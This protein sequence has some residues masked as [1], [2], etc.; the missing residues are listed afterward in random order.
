MY[1][2][3]NFIDS[4]LSPLIGSG[5]IDE[6][7]DS[8]KNINPNS[9]T[10]VKNIISNTIKPEFEKNS[11]DFKKIARETLAFYLTT[12]KIDFGRLYNS[13]L[14]AFDHPDNPKVFFIWVWQILFNNEQYQLDNWEDFKEVND[15]R[16]PN[17]I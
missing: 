1:V 4:I 8:Y 12:E 5:D 17:Y 3:R 7:M 13:L 15:P 14:I 16:E 10:E 11:T 9:E 2:N 6:E